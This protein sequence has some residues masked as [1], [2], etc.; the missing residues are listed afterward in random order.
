MNGTVEGFEAV[1]SVGFYD[2]FGDDGA[3]RPANIA[4]GRP[5]ETTYRVAETAIE[6]LD[7]T[8]RAGAQFSSTLQFA[9]RSRFRVTAASVR[10]STCR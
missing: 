7:N 1:V 3:G 10:G 6:R 4:D 9:L 8:L 5:Y 2:A